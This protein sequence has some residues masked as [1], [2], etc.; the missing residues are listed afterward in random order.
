MGRAS[1]GQSLYPLHRTRILHLVRHA[2]G[3]HNVAIKNARKNDPNNK[4]LLS[5]QFFDAQLTDFGWKQVL[6]IN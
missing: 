3:F 2:Q 1:G 4:A 5:H 6:L